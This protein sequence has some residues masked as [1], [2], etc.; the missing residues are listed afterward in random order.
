MLRPGVVNRYIQGVVNLYVQGII[1]SY[2]QGSQIPT[3]RGQNPNPN[4]AQSPNKSD[5]LHKGVLIHLLCYFYIWA[6]A[7]MLTLIQISPCAKKTL[8][9]YVSYVTVFYG[10]PGKLERE[11]RSHFC[12]NTRENSR[13]P[14]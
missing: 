3:S 11:K 5:D 8:L 9:H 6:C 10:T 4:I 2:V 13:L 1:S 14:S 7:Q 12:Q